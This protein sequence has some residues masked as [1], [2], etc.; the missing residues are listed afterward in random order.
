[1]RWIPMPLALSL[2]VAATAGLAADEPLRPEQVRQAMGLKLGAWKTKSRLVD[3]QV[4]TAPGGDPAETEQVVAK[5]RALLGKEV[6]QVQCL[7]DRPD[8]LSLP[9]LHPP[10][11][12]DYSRLEVR[13]GRFAVTSQCKEPNSDEAFAVAVEGTYTPERMIVSSDAT[14]PHPRGRMRIK[15]NAESR[16]TGSC[17]SLPVTPPAED[18]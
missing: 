18:D 16:F 17:D 9:G 6:I 7:R 8:R 14:A 13:D 15:L 5:F 11:G 4:E 3:L 12:C 2:A 10:P 1:M